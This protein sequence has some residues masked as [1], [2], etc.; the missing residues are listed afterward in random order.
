MENK[1]MYTMDCLAIILITVILWTILIVTMLNISRIVE[2]Q[3]LKAIIFIIGTLVGAFAT[4]SCTAVILHLKKN[5]KS[6]Y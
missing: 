4:A 2:D 6:L 1:R 5:R 3:T